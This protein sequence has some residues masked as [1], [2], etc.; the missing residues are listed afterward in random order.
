[1]QKSKTNSPLP[2]RVVRQKTHIHQLNQQDTTYKILR[3]LYALHETN[4][5]DI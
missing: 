3:L 2:L 4:R 1:M 5:K